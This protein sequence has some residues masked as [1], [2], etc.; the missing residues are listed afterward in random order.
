M[1]PTESSKPTVIYKPKGF[2]ESAKGKTILAT[3]LGIILFVILLISLNY[4]DIVSV[5]QL[6][7][8]PKRP[9]MSITG[10]PIKITLVPENYGYRAGDLTLNCPVESEFCPS[11]KLVSLNKQDSVLYKANPGSTVS[12]SIKIPSLENIGVSED[13]KK[14]KKYFYESVVSKDGVSCYTIAYTLPSDATFGNILNLPIL[15]ETSRIATLGTKTFQIE[16]EE[17]NV[18]IQVRNTPMDPGVPCS[19]IKKS[20]EFFKAFN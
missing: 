3:G 12:A 18:I 19:L 20:P 17:A 9:N 15:N 11:Q 1:E 8:L 10:T 7:F 5:S 13:R 16:G 4:F 14:G 2:F 6:S